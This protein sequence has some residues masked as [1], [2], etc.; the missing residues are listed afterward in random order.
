MPILAKSTGILDAPITTIERFASKISITDGCWNWTGSK[1]PK[2]YG[3]FCIYIDGVERNRSSHRVMYELV[4]GKDLDG[5]IEVIDHL[6][7]NTSCVNPK[8][9]E[10]VSSAVNIHRGTNQI[11]VYAARN[12][13]SKGHEYT[14]ENTS[15]YRSRGFVRGRKCKMCSNKY[16]RDRR[17]TPEGR[18]YDNKLARDYRL[19][20]KQINSLTKLEAEL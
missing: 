20:L 11:A 3:Q 6:C 18:A 4:T 1:K 2:G 12:H 9:L 19:R 8:H 10:L 7:R 15:Y 17:K 16:M 5:T 14:P 13:C